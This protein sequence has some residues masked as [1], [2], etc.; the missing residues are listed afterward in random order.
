MQN[1]FN[2]IFCYFW[3]E[4]SER[5]LIRSTK[6]TTGVHLPH[7]VFSFSN[8]FL[9]IL[10]RIKLFLSTRIFYSCYLILRIVFIQLKFILKAFFCWFCEIIFSIFSAFVGLS[11]RRT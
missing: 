4:I 3:R 2:C 6:T 5:Q 1:I 9:L 10:A 8:F 7:V 11:G